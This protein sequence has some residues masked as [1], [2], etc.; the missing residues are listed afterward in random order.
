MTEND[1]PIDWDQEH[2]RY[3][4][5]SQDT[6]AAMRDFDEVAGRLAAEELTERSPDGRVAV[7]VNAGGA[8]VSVAFRRGTLQRYGNAT[9]GD[10]I[11]RTIRAAQ[12][13]AR[14]EFDRKVGAAVPA[15][16]VECERLIRESIRE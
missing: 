16:V 9:L 4:R 6:I 10:I 8:V 13:R 2:A 12:L 15:E 14:E 3:E 7:R 5:M 1:A 11:A